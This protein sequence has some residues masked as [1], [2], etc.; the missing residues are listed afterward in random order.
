MPGVIR[1][2]I[3]DERILSQSYNADTGRHAILSCDDNSAWLYLHEPSDDPSQ[4][5]AVES[6]GFVFNLI[7]PIQ[8]PEI[9]QYR[10]APPPIVDS[11]ATQQAVCEN[12][13]DLNWSIFGCDKAPWLIVS[14]HRNRQPI[15]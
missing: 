6:S 10:P 11:F 12:V 1:L 8:R 2:R 3:M 14:K 15:C 4:I 5:R 7:E 13:D 9:E